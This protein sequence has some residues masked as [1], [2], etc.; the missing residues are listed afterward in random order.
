[1]CV[2]ALCLV[3]RCDHIF[4]LA[5]QTYASLP[6]YKCHQQA[7]VEFFLLWGVMVE[8]V[9]NSSVLQTNT[10]ILPSALSYFPHAKACCGRGFQNLPRLQW[11]HA[12]WCRACILQIAIYFNATLGLSLWPCAIPCLPVKWTGCPF[13]P[14]ESLIWEA[15]L[16]N[17]QRCQDNNPN[18]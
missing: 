8:Q 3:G 2:N 5:L 14:S 1:M 16:S 13:P 11:M 10:S 17:S 9:G 15:H 12:D 18:C 6:R 7:L 4:H